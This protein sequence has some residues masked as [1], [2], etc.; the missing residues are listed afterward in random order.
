MTLQEKF[1]E[2]IYYIEKSVVNAEPNVPQSLSRDTGLNLRMLGDAFQFITDI[3][4][5]KYIRQ[6]RMVYA[7]LRRIEQD[8][9]VE[10]IVSIAGFS[11]AASFTKACKN[12]FNLTPT[13]ITEEI[14]NNHKP[15]SFARVT[16]GK[17]DSQLEEEMFAATKNDTICGVTV[18]QFAEIKQVIEIGALY[19]LSD[20][21]AEFVYRLSQGSK[22][23][24]EQAAEFYEDF[25]LQIENG[26]YF[27]GQDVFEMAELS[28][29]YDLSFSETQGIMYELGCNGYSSIRDLPQGYF[30]IYFCESN[31]R[32]GWSVEYICEIAEAIQSSKL[33]SSKI[34][35]YVLFAESV[36]G[37]IVDVIEHL[38]EYQAKWDKYLSSAWNTEFYNGDSDDL[39]GYRSIWEVSEF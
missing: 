7:L 33:D 12:E 25:T 31:N 14:L 21:E 37:D 15:L 24:T 13:Q 38:E 16:S 8:L 9:P 2:I 34:D 32:Y 11:D 6:R 4:L 22:I 17:G 39:F 10:E 20:D 28:C 1:D 3:T 18:D 27:G 26:S 30:D 19:G 36:C 5:I 23:T 29:S 35:E